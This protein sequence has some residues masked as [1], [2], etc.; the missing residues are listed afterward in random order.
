MSRKLVWL[1]NTSRPVRAILTVLVTLIIGPIVAG[2]VGIMESFLIG[3]FQ[4]QIG[5]IDGFSGSLG[6]LLKL[7]GTALFILR[8]GWLQALVTGVV[9]ALTGLVM[10]R[11]PISIAIIMGILAA[12]ASS[13]FYYS[14]LLLLGTP[15]DSIQLFSDLMMISV[16]LAG[17]IVAWL[18]CRRFWWE[19]TA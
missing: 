13:L 6:L 14:R 4:H 19:K 3:L 10:N 2:I 18:I 5:P 1:S 16:H 15:N 7:I 11:I 12:V 8:L 9:F 17:S